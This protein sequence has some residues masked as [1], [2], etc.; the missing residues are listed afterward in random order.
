MTSQGS[1]RKTVIFSALLLAFMAVNLGVVSSAQAAS[2]P[3]KMVPKS[4]LF[5]VRVNSLDN[6][7]TQTD[8]FLAGV[9]PIGVS[10]LAKAQLGQFLGSANLAG[11]DTAG[12]FAV[13]SPLPGGAPDP[14]RVG[15]LVPMTSYQQFVSGNTNVSEAN[16]QGISQIGPPSSPMM[17]AIQVGD[18]ALVS[19][20]GNEEAL[21]QAK[22]AL[23][24]STAGLGGSLDATELKQSSA[25]PVWAYA[26]IKMIGQIFGPMIQAQ[27]QQIKQGM[28]AMSAQ[29]QDQAG[30]AQAA[31]AMDMY[32]TMLDTVLKETNFISLSLL[33]S[34]T[35]M[36]LGLTVASTPGT[37]MANMLKGSATK[38]SNKLMGYLQ[39][40]AV[41][42][43][44]GSMDGPFWEKF[45]QAYI[46]MMPKLMGQ[47][48]SGDALEQI[49][50]MA[51]DA[52]DAFAGPIAGSM[53]TKPGSSPPFEVKYVAALKDAQKLRQVMEQAPKMMKEGPVADFYKNMGMK[54]SFDL[55]QK[56]QTH[57]GVAIDAI[58]FKMEATN[59]D[60]VEAQQMKAMFGDGFHVNIAVVDNLLVYA[61][62]KDEGAAVRGM[63]DKVK[64]GGSSSM[65][66]EVKSAADLIPGADKADF[67]VTINALRAMGMAAAIAPIPLPQSQM[68]SR[69]NMALAGTVGD[70]KLKI[71][72][73]VPKQHVQE[74]MG[75]VMQM[76][77][78]QGGMQP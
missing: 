14:T 72:L 11:V 54:V 26:N 59:P 39:D 2:D 7:L 77:M 29:G 27:L 3:M 16:A 28:A 12:G 5:C 75:V 46:D 62:A 48:V 69:S 67:L 47:G 44:A 66:A 63:I 56:A 42:N 9:S 19:P 38:Q 68:P 61:L 43:F 34:P 70:G 37:E 10:M 25:A 33:P 60:S 35:S 40:G 41:M 76:Q 73:A 6:A 58:T 36:R 74:I 22:T 32:G 31:A 78:Q 51:T 55:K 71:D 8:M 64:A 23:T 1:P 15:V 65:P 21:V 57:K 50:T 24:S 18:F 30:T 20:A 49:K 13:F 52:M 53:S 17:S 45:N 4:C